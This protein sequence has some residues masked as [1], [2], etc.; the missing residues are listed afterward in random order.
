MIKNTLGRTGLEVTPLGYGSMGLRGPQTWGVRVVADEAADAFLNAV[1]DAG[2]NFIDTAPI[3]ASPSSAS[4]N[5]SVP[6]AT[7][8]SWPPSVVA[9]TPSTMTTWKSITTGTRM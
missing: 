4:A 6:D 1:L 7:N 5:T 3:T 8:I 9:C 2:I